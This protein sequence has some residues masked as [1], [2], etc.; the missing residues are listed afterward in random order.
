MI[1]VIGTSFAGYK[2]IAECGQGAYGS[3]FLV[4]DAL[5]KRFALKYVS[6]VKAGEYEM[7]GL[8]NYMSL[9]PLQ[10]SLIQ[11][12]H[13]GFDEGCLFYVMEAA[14]KSSGNNGEYLPD[15]LAERLL[16]RHH[17][18]AGET[19][20]IANSLLCGLEALHNAGMLHR[21]IKPENI[22]FVDGT[23]KLADPGL[24]RHFDETIS[25]AGTPG[26]LAPELVNGA[27]PSPCTDIYALGKVI[28]R[29]V[30]G[31][32][33]ENY[34]E[35]PENVPI[36]E[37]Y[38]ICRPLMH[39]CNSNPALRCQNCDEA[40][41]A[42]P[43][44]IRKHGA[45][46]RLRDRLWLQAEFRKRFIL[47]ASSMLLLI[48]IISGIF[49]FA[50]IRSAERQRQQLREQEVLRQ[51]HEQKKKLLTEELDKLDK[52]SKILDIQLEHLGE[53]P[54]QTELDD[55]RRML[56]DDKLEDAD[57]ILRIRQEKLH[58]LAEKHMPPLIKGQDKVPLTE[59][60]FREVGMAFGY[61]ASPL[62]KLLQKEKR[63]VLE[64]KTGAAANRFALNYV[65]R[66]GSAYSDSKYSGFKM[67]FV[68]PGCF[69]SP[70]TKSVQ[71][72]EYPYWILSTEVKA[73]FFS[74]IVNDLA[75]KKRNLP[76]QAQEY[77]G[78]N[79]QLYFCRKLNEGILSYHAFPPGYAI[80][81]PTEAEWEFAAVGGW[82]NRVPPERA[83]TADNI[84]LAPGMGEANPLGIFNIDDNLTEVMTPYPELPP[85]IA[86]AAICRGSNT[87]YGAKQTGITMRSDFPFDQ[88]HCQG[89][90]LR[91]VIAPTPP[92]YY[93]EAWS[94]G[95]EI[96]QTTLNGRI[97]AGFTTIFAPMNWKQAIE[98]AS[99]LGAELPNS[100][101]LPHLSEIYTRLGLVKGYPCHMAIHYSDGA[102][103]DLASGAPVVWP[104]NVKRIPEANEERKALYA[105]TKNV[106]SIKETSHA[107]IFLLRWNSQDA[108]SKRREA[109]MQRALFHSFAFG[110]K[111]FGVYRFYSPGYALRS[112]A[113]F[114]GLK[115][116]V[117]DKEYI[118]ELAAKVPS[119]K[120]ACALGPIRFFDKW[121]QAD[122]TI[123]DFTTDLEII[124]AGYDSISVMVLASKQGKLVQT[125]CV[126]SFIVELP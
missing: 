51:L 63:K 44:S 8:R 85:K 124:Y 107:P 125:E 77:L 24:I 49:V 122:G 118:S 71:C 20:D 84:N 108:F 78:W 10:A 53:K 109:F 39:L 104:N 75:Y 116:P 92:N 74:L 22:V 69:F 81:M 52:T 82:A 59:E 55:A 19:L 73:E 26:Y 58:A 119:G 66:L 90:G 76:F 79:D 102:W 97:Y 42:L 115:Q 113:R 100:K 105:S 62:G 23:P 15:T 96:R 31:L 72:V 64:S 121:E 99:Y 29:V 7:K 25:F 70:A 56:A 21:D 101:D 95:V 46:L 40:R 1:P 16:H 80:R 60:S 50:G 5:G 12:F 93:N 111:R 86:G 43:R 33:P 14:D 68:P 106:N 27:K 67:V 126:D 110:E 54:R 91:P 65:P 17:L 34:P 103:R 41:A 18:T 9:T 4:E 114:I 11:I 13:C 112:F 32:P 98:F 88:N 61:L 117:L 35:Q 30:T 37:L 94:R 45:L 48:A 28:Y 6:S 38:Q 57:G 123:L 3:V 47:Y 83:V 36:S 89:I 2:I 120:H 87:R